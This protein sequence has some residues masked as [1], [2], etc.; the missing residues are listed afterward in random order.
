MIP[1]DCDTVN[2]NSEVLSDT[3]KDES[4]VLLD[5]EMVAAAASKE[6]KSNR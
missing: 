3:W 4:V 2:A 5:N 6:N 1:E